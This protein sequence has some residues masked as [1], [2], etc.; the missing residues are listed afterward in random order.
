MVMGT[1][2]LAQAV[3]DARSAG[4]TVTA[5][6][7][8]MMAS[9]ALWVGS[10]ADHVTAGPMAFVGSIGVYGVVI[11]SSRAA[12]NA[13]IKVHVIASGGVKG[14]NV[15]GAPVSDAVLADEQRMIASINDKFLAAV[16]AGRKKPAEE[17]RAL[18]TGQVWLGEEAQRLGLVDQITYQPQDTTPAQRK[19]RLAMQDLLNLAAEHPAQA[20]LIRDLAKAGKTPEQISAAIAEAH[21]AEQF[22]ALKSEA[23]KNKAEAD[24]LGAELAAEKAAR[25]KAEEDLAKLK[26]FAVTGKDPGE[27]SA[28]T[29]KPITRAALA[30]MNPQQAREH[31]S[32]GGIVI[33]DQPAA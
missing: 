3:R 14:G 7:E 11:D 21:R 31:F 13:G 8:G 23:E 16:A 6:V 20:G 33:D 1:D 12:E 24:R 4:K 28:R 29:A 26:A 15:R 10:Q 27:D 17:M 19:E 9:A 22:V 25:A 2:D 30:A 18:N 32:K 5:H